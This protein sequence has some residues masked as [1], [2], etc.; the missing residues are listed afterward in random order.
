MYKYVLSGE[1]HKGVDGHW[2]SGI[3]RLVDLR[4]MQSIT[5]PSQYVQSTKEGEG[6]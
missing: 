6:G 5:R 1:K 2:E 3:N 4:L